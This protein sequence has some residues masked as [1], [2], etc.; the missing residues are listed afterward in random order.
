MQQGLDGLSYKERLDRLGLFSLEHWRLRGELKDIYKMRGIDQR[1]SQYL[2]TK[3]GES[4]TRGHRFKMRGERYRRIQRGNF[5]TQRLVS[6]WNEL[7]ETGV[8]AGTI[9]SFK[10]YLDSDMSKMGMEGY[11]PN[12]GNCN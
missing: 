8:E 5:F 6:V 4:K 2:F 9:L 10:K 11:G 12:A 1:D 7:P 3:V